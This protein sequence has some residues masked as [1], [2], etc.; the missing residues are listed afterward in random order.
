MAIQKALV[1][2]PS[3]RLDEGLVSHL[4]RSPVDLTR[5]R[6]QWRPTSTP[7]PCTPGKSSKCRPPTTAPT[8]SSSRTQW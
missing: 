4:E 8:A 7:W 6:E 5:A 1:R 3:I 2:R